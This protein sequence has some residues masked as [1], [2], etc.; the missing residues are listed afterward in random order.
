MTPPLVLT[1]VRDAAGATRDIAMAD[2]VIR[3]AATPGAETVDARGMI[4]LPRLADAHVH[5][6]K[7]LLGE[8]WIPHRA[9]DEPGERAA[10]ERELLEG[11]TL[12]SVAERG[13]RLVTR[14]VGHGTTLLQSHV[15][16]EDAASLR[17]VEALLAL[18]E[19]LAPF[20]DIAL[21]AF[22]QRGLSTAPATRRAL[23]DAVRLGAEAVGGLD[24]Q[25]FDGDR[26]AHLDVVF[27]LA[28]RYGRRV[29]VHVHEPATV[30]TATI[31]AMA[32]RA[33]ALGLRGRCAVSHAYALAQVDDV[34]LGRTATRMADA[35]MTVVT[36]VPGD[37]RLPPLT[38]LRELGVN[39]VVASD[40][41]R[42]FWSPFGRADQLERAGLA[43][44][45]AGWRTDAGLADALALVTD[46]PARAL[47]RQPARLA[48][49]DPA[50]LVLVPAASLG[51][52]LVEAPPGRVVVRGG[53][54]VAR[55]GRLIG[56][57]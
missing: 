4:A 25:V 18:A 1:G 45:C 46:G 41:V 38:R 34:E 14:A 32:D 21:V 37:G 50:D 26:D 23:E 16:V 15:D 17:R 28:E 20:A 8:R 44:Y 57:G 27:G 22:P 10:L 53:R 42:D 51:E 11:G 35:G 5:L 7:T 24:P 30:G 36:S 33:L 31:R 13:R 55:D 54:V 48:V 52:A 2:G 56:A 49:G 19:E 43:A 47:H 40:N 9:A 6:D 39:A 3:A 12:A 29:D